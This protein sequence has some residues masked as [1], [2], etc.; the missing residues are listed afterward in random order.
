MAAMVLP[1]PLP[2]DEN[3]VLGFLTVM[4]ICFVFTLA[5]VTLRTWVR[6][7]MVKSFGADDWFMVIA[8]VSQYINYIAP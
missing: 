6:L 2:P 1:N 5:F 8:L 4:I 7:T 3:R